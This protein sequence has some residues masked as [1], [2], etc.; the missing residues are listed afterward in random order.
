[1][2]LSAI[3]LSICSYLIKLPLRRYQLK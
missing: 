2:L 1:L 3:G